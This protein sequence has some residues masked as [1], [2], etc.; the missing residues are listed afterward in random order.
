MIVCV[1]GQ[2]LVQQKCCRFA[3]F[4]A[5]AAPLIVYNRLY[6]YVQAVKVTW[7]RARKK[8][9]IG[10]KYSWRR[11]IVCVLGQYLVQQKCCRFV[12]FCATA[13]PLI[14]Y[15]RLY[16]YVQAV[17]VMWTR[18]R[19]KDTIG[20]KYYWCR[21]ISSPPRDSTLPVHAGQP[22]H[23]SPTPSRPRP[24][25]ISTSSA[26]SR[27]TKANLDLFAQR[28]FHLNDRYHHATTRSGSSRIRL[29]DLLRLRCLGRSF[30][31]NCPKC[32][33]E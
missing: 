9:T 5:T 18:A 7:P 24:M 15:N 2:Y 31:D 28:P 10:P 20:P 22:L 12:R 23:L 32:G 21:M 4:C 29:D 33:V 8:D 17:K 25:T 6:I 19:K 27:E 30:D 1:L 26:P 11:M 13:A 14:V 3:R 16:I